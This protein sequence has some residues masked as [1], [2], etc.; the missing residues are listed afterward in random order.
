MDNAYAPLSLLE[1]KGSSLSLSLSNFFLQ[2]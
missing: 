2:E 1:E